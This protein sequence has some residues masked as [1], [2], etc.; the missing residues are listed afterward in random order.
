[1]G[2]IGHAQATALTSKEELNSMFDLEG[3]TPFPS[4]YLG[5]LNF[6]A[7]ASKFD[8]GHGHGYRNELKI[9]ARQRLGLEKTHEHFSAQVTPTLPD[10]AKTIVAQYHVDGLDTILKVYVQ[11]TADSRLIDGKARNGIFDVMVKIRGTSGR[12]VT[13][14]LGTVR[15]GER[16][17]L[18]INFVVG[19]ATVTVNTEKN[20]TIQTEPTR[21]KGDNR[22][23]YFKFGDYLQALDPVTLAHTTSPAKWDE[24]YLKNQINSSQISFS[25]IKFER[26]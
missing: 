12:E 18:D 6:S 13:T 17:A 21:I 15:S 24:Y 26:K 14:A 25:Q 20:G 5:T 2:A 16:F 23:I 19:E 7:L 8:S 22:N 9:S 3:N 11:D 10:G 1:M 4:P